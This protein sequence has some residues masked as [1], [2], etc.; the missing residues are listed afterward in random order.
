[1]LAISMTLVIVKGDAVGRLWA[2]GGGRPTKGRWVGAESATNIAFE[3]CGMWWR[4]LNKGGD[5]LPSEV[6]Q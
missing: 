1:M 4:A 5:G 3:C 6:G 2:C